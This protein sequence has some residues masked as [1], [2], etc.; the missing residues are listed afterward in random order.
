MTATRTLPNSRTKLGQREGGSGLP[1]TEVIQE[2]GREAAQQPHEFC[3]INERHGSRLI[4][5]NVVCGLRG[6]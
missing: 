1:E 3:M 6:A 5:Q 4:Y 2:R